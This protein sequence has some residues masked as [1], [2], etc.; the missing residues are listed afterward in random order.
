MTA[1]EAL[2]QFLLALGLDVNHPDLQD[3]PSRVA[4]LFRQDLLD[5]YQKDPAKILANTFPTQ[6]ASLV[7]IGGVDF[8]STCPHHLLPVLG[9]AKIGYLPMGKVVGFSQIVD[10]VEALSHRLVLQEQLGAQICNAIVEHVGS[11]FVACQLTAQQL[12][13]MVRGN[14]RPRS[15]VTTYAFAGARAG[16]SMFKEMFFRAKEERPV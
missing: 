5:G 2:Q 15:A 14:K 4:N 6:G 16:D 7:C 10:L 3:T 13:M 1:E 8:E 9:V 12:C 11:P